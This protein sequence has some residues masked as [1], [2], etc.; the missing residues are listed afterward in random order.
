MALVRIAEAILRHQRSVLTVS[1]LLVNEYGLRDVCLSVPCVVS[2]AGVERVV[3]ADLPP[4][5]RQ[6]LVRSASVLHDAI[7][8]LRGPG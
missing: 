2:Q 5:E 7:A 4:Q 3:E 6:A 8:Q 1:S